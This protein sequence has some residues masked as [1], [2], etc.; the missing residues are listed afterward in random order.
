[1]I[2][3]RSLVVEHSLTRIESLGM[4]IEIQTFR[5]DLVT[6]FPGFGV[7]CCFFYF[8]QATWRKISELSFQTK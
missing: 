5:S 2:I 4:G 6:D 7:E 1:M 3:T 8:R